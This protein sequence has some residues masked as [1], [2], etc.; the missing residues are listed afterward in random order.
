MKRLTAFV[1][2][3][4]LCAVLTTG[5]SNND[6]RNDTSSAVSQQVSS[7]EAA[8]S[9]DESIVVSQAG[10]QL[11][12]LLFGNSLTYTGQMQM[13]LEELIRSQGKKDKVLRRLSP[14]FTLQQHLTAMESGNFDEML[15]ADIVVFQEFGAPGVG[16]VD[17]IKKLMDMFDEATKFYF[18]LTE[19]DIPYRIGELSSFENIE[20]IP[21]GYAH[22]LL[23]QSG[24]NYEML[25]VPNDY[26][27]NT[28]YGYIGA[29]TIYG[30][31][32]GESPVGLSYDFLYESTKKL[33]PGFNDMIKAASVSFIQKKVNEALETDLEE[34]KRIYPQ[35]FPQ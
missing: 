15:T 9:G 20:F 8:S 11:E 32:Y 2:V 21:S 19:M 26:H 35:T 18:L 14:G 29:L 22:D 16:T 6:I 7:S 28:L 23:I 25:H 27:P 3:I 24:Y 17:S 31:I 4:C 33:I 13:A 1:A 12:I 5:C 30:K 10:E 34:L